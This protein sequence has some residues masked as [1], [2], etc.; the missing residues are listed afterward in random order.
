M[1][2]SVGGGFV[3][4]RP[5]PISQSPLSDVL[6]LILLGAEFRPLD[7]SFVLTTALG[8]AVI[9][10]AWGALPPQGPSLFPSEAHPWAGC[11]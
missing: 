7:T 9:D 11:N 3:P 2:A 6:Q 10:S 1:I 4:P 8:Q 5:P